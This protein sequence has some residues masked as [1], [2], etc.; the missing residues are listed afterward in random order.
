MSRLRISGAIPLLTI[1]TF[2]ALTAKTHAD[3]VKRLPFTAET[4]VQSQS[5]TCWIFGK[6]SGTSTGFFLEYFDFSVSLSFHRRCSLQFLSEGRETTPGNLQKIKSVLL[7]LSG[8]TG[9]WISFV[10]LALWSQPITAAVRFRVQIGP[11]ENC[12]GRS[13]NG[14][15]FPARYLV[16]PCQ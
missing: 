14:T 13:G 8:N 1:C 9:Q 16:L 10:L 4:R 2:M 12:G 6:Q 11:S 5:V 7:R 3:A 15:H